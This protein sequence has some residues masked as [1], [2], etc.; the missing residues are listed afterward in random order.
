MSAGKTDNGTL[1]TQDLVL[2][3]TTEPRRGMWEFERALGLCKMAQEE[4]EGRIDGI[5]RMEAGFEIILCDFSK[6]VDLV[7]ATRV[8]GGGVRDRSG[9][10]GV[11]SHFRYMEAVADRYA[12]I[13]GGRVR[14]DYEHFVSAFAYP[15]DLFREASETT[16]QPPLPRLLN[17][18]SDNLAEIRSAVGKMVLEHDAVAAARESFDWQ[19]TADMIVARYS[20]PLQYLT[21]EKLAN[22]TLLG[23]YLEELL[24][25]FIDY[26]SRDAISEAAHCAEQ[27]TSGVPTA[28]TSL[29]AAAVHSIA[30][31]ICT[32][33]VSVLA[34]IPKDQ[35]LSTAITQLDELVAYLQWPSWKQ[36]RGCA[37][38]ELC[39]VPLWPFGAVEDHKQPQC[40]NATR[41]MDRRGY[42]GIG[43]GGPPPPRKGE[44]EK[45]NGDM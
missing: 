29:A 27:F 2:L 31:S 17:V 33:L 25:P 10:A 39:F 6:D 26:D 7:R 9:V 34:A 32:T 19:A 24:R 35:T 21:C 20:T 3:N 36:C 41:V 12:G 13:G 5:V 42:W 14:L 45:G 37:D 8:G 15:L 1:D 44:G 23:I 16:G 38:D 11:T 40:L 22:A 43:R 4:W 18:S 30:N 28:G